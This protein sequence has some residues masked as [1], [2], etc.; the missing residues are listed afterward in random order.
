MESPARTLPTTTPKKVL[1][2]I[3][4]LPRRMRS[5]TLRT[6]R[7][8]ERLPTHPPLP[9]LPPQTGARNPTRT[10]TQGKENAPPAPA[11]HDPP[12]RRRPAPLLPKSSV[13]VF[14]LG[15]PLPRD[16]DMPSPPLSAGFPHTAPGPRPTNPHPHPHTFPTT[17][18]TTTALTA[19]EPWAPT[20]DGRIV[21]KVWVPTTDDI[22][23]VRVAG[24]APLAAVGA[25]VAAKLGFA[26]SFAAVMP[27]G[28][29]RAV[30]DEAAFRAWVA[31]RVRGG[32]NTLL[33]AHRLGLQ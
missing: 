31:G 24:D 17:T 26:V 16:L 9:I 29:L 13:H 7:A 20:P 30:G 23:K 27:D 25:R 10:P 8:P 11:Q 22:W 28:H 3:H 12:R 15:L 21:L 4:N 32:R 14:G 6:D 1:A 2:A 33:T 5:A 18:T 19:T